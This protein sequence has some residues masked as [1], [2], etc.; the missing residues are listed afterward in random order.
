METINT[1]ILISSV[2][3]KVISIIQNTIDYCETYHVKDGL[4]KMLT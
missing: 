2:L 1:F 3:P 4:T